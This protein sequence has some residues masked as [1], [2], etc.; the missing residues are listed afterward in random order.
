MD[1][2]NPKSSP[3]VRK[4]TQLGDYWHSAGLSCERIAQQSHFKRGVK[5]E[6]VANEIHDNVK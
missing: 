4:N 6:I 5:V 2:E 3:T 1:T